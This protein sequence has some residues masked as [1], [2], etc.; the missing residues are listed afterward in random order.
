MHNHHIARLADYLDHN[1]RSLDSW[2]D[3]LGKS[4]LSSPTIDLAP[5]WYKVFESVVKHCLDIS[6]KPVADTAL[7]G[8]IGSACVR[9]QGQG[10]EWQI[11]SQ[12]VVRFAVFRWLR[13]AV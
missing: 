9:F 1:I 2:R 4:S 13:F 7:D 6:S 10:L 11:R 12:S 5:G 8:L 3:R